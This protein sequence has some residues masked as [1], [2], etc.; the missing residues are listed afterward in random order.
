MK[1]LTLNDKKDDY[2]NKENS[3]ASDANLSLGSDVSTTSTIAPEISE[4]NMKKARALIRKGHFKLSVPVEGSCDPRTSNQAM[5]T[6]W[7]FVV[8]L[9]SNMFK[10]DSLVCMHCQYL[11]DHACLLAFSCLMASRVKI[12]GGWYGRGYSMKLGDLETT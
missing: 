1:S 8:D 7:R 2:T 12:H 9:G 3:V 6:L 4:V 11:A 10:D 5:E